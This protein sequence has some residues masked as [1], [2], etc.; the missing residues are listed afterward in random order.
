MKR[1]TLLA[2]APL[3]LAALSARPARAA[4]PEIRFA[5]QYSM[6]YLQF[7]V[8]EHQ[9]LVEKHAAALGLPEVKV[10][11]VT[12]NGPDAIN[13]ALLSDSVDIV[14][15]GIPALVTFW[16]R[17]AGTSQ[18]VR[19]IT[20]LSS[21]P[22]LL[23]TRNPALKTIADLG[24][25]DRIAVPSVKVSI[26]AV[27]LQMAT[28]KL[29]GKANYT[30]Y[31]DL[32]VAMSPPDATIALLSGGGEVDC[33]FSVPPYQEQQLQKPGIH[34]LLNSFDVAGPH[35]FTLTWAKAR[36]RNENPVL[37][38]ALLAALRE[39]T[40]IVNADKKAAAALWLEDSHSKLPLDEVASIV[41]GPQVTWTLTPQGTL[42]YANFMHDAGSVKKA[43][44]SWK[45]MFFPEVHDLPGN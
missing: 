42:N 27:T 16:A 9:N 35:S 10:S 15:G 43:P 4:V 21:Q 20:A 39:A 18:E 2:A 44:E 5:R 30:K 3:G 1:R 37:Y 32:T 22:C 28:A 19:G 38:K 25:G 7:N 24:A 11:W 23:N 14:S 13:T 31:D 12:F 34:T 41:S 17:T 8:M 40:D 36:F 29:F 26:Q 45:D 33:A 6:G